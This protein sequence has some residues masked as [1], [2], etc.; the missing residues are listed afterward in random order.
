MLGSV[1]IARLAAK[2]SA[3]PSRSLANDL[4]SCT[5]GIL[6]SLSKWQS[7]HLGRP[8]PP[9]RCDFLKCPGWSSQSRTILPPWA[10]K[11]CRHTRCV[12]N[13]SIAARRIVLAANVLAQWSRRH[14][15][16]RS[17]T[18]TRIVV[19]PLSWCPGPDSNR[20]DRLRSGD[21]KSPVSTSF[22]TRAAWNPSAAARK[23][24]GGS[25]ILIDAF[26]SGSFRPRG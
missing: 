23:S 12:R 15:G 3:K 4:K 24:G 1:W 20:H 6:A 22:T 25:H 18:K 5:V 26:P 19:L 2:A 9:T 7:Q 16:T 11:C 21:F 13:L 17:G 14:S 10:L 8:Q